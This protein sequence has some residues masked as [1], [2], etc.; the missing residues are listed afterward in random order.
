MRS[1]DPAD[2]TPPVFHG[3]W[4]TPAFNTLLRNAIGWGLGA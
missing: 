4:E 2:T 1:A 3:P